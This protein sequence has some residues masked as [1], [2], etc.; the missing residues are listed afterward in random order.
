MSDALVQHPP[1][2]QRAGLCRQ[3]APALGCSEVSA[4]SVPAKALVQATQVAPVDG[5]LST[6]RPHSILV[7]RITGEVAN[8]VVALDDHVAAKESE[9]EPREPTF[10][11]AELSTTC[12]MR[13]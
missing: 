12:R 11:R 9:L 4:T 13:G 8:D 5:S 7:I 2:A 1:R 10:H 3:I 6:G